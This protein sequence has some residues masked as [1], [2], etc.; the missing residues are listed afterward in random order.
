MALES[1]GCTH[2]GLFRIRRQ[3]S[4]G[5]GELLTLPQLT[6]REFDGI[7]VLT[8][9]ALFQKAKVRIAFTGRTGGISAEPYSALNLGSH[10]GDSLGD[11]LVN[12]DRLLCALAPADCHLLV[13]NQVH[14]TV[15]LP[16]DSNE[17]EYVDDARRTISEGAD[18]VAVSCKKVAALLCY[19]DCTP[20]IVVSPTGRFA[21]VHAGWRG[22]V[23]GIVGK[24]VRLLAD[25][26]GDDPSQ[27]NVYIGPHIRQ[28]C[29]ETGE[30]VTQRFADQFGEE[31]VVDSRH[32]SLAQAVSIDAMRAGVAAERIVDACICTKCNPEDYFSYRAS[33]GT[34]GR[35]G[36]FAVRL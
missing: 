18:G 36:A 3:V 16:I 29:F 26:D 20:V 13:P 4:D 24:A 31:C 21:V 8:D 27:F 14:G 22:A 10:V 15:V 30:E 6:Q 17:D 5:V 19:A 28:E 7:P 34:C 11:V 25:A 33:G 23:E 1:P 32:V 9:D 12:R 35:H 2:P